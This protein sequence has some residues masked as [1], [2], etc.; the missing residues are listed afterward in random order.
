VSQR[1]IPSTKRK[2]GR[3]GGKVRE[4]RREEER[5]RRRKRRRIGMEE[6]SLCWN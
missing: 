2:E 4:G 1:S 5:K 6:F 3:E